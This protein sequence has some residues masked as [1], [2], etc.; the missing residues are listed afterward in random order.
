M[1]L[2]LFIFSILLGMHS[3]AME[4]SEGSFSSKGN[5]IDHTEAKSSVRSLKELAI[6]Q[7]ASAIAET[8][9]NKKGKNDAY[10]NKIINQKTGLSYD[11]K[12][13]Q[14][15]KN[16]AKRRLAQQLFIDKVF[17]NNNISGIQIEILN[18]YVAT[19]NNFKKEN[20]ETHIFI[21]WIGYQSICILC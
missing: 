4:S 18:M 5:A 8:F 1:K 2:L 19:I 14:P 17:N 21:S 3:I 15:L 6:Q 10:V 13:F 16:A 7:A 11:H 20:Y 9:L 12:L